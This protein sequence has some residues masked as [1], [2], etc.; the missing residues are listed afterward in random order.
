M[1]PRSRL[2]LTVSHRSDTALLNL[3][4]RSLSRAS[5]T[6]LDGMDRCPICEVIY[7]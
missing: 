2:S 7:G 6:L 5:A 1:V 3:A 4:M